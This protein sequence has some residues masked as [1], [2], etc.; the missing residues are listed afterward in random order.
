MGTNFY[1][2]YSASLSC[3]PGHGCNINWGSAINTVPL[4]SVTNSSQ[5]ITSIAVL[6]NGSLYV[7]DNYFESMVGV[8]Q[9]Q[10]TSNQAALWQL[11]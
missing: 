8:Y 5:G 9:S 10:S 3:N 7:V 6:S 2:I 11:D 4:S 1:N